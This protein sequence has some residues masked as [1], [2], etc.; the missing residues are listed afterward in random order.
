MHMLCMSKRVTIILD[1]DLVKKLREI[2][3]KLI[4]E[5][6]SSVS[7]SRVLNDVVR[8]GLKKA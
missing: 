7:F 8:E 2:Q 6:T 5:S 3:S 1:D 4:K